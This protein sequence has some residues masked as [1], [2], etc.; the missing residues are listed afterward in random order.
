[1]LASLP[2]LRHIS[3]Q[4][5]SSSSWCGSSERRPADGLVEQCHWGA[6]LGLFDQCDNL[7]RA[8]K[9]LASWETLCIM[10]HIRD[11]EI[12]GACCPTSSTSSAL[13]PF[14]PNGISIAPLLPQCGERAHGNETVFFVSWRLEQRAILATDP[15]ARLR[16]GRY[17]SVYIT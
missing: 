15:T 8:A 1:M 3:T 7:G 9:G 2:G 11:A 16:S 10:P 4:M 6:F 17:Q 13:R 12:H 14:F 5:L